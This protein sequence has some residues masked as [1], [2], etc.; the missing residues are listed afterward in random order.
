MSF[1]QSSNNRPS[2]FGMGS[3]SS[4]KPTPPSAPISF[5][6]EDEHEQSTPCQDE[7]YLTLGKFSFSSFA[8]RFTSP[9]PTEVKGNQKDDSME[10]SSHDDHDQRSKGPS[11]EINE[12]EMQEANDDEVQPPPL[13]YESRSEVSEEHEVS[14]DEANPCFESQKEK[15]R[16]IEKM[17]PEPKGEDVFCV[18]V[19]EPKRVKFVTPK[20]LKVP[21]KLS[22]P[23]TKHSPKPQISS[24]EPRHV[25]SPEL[26]E[27]PTFVKA[28]NH[29]EFVQ[30]EEQHA[31]LTPISEESDEL[32]QSQRGPERIPQNSSDQRLFHFSPSDSNRRA[33]SRFMRENPQLPLADDSCEVL[34]E[35]II[36]VEKLLEIGTT[37]SREVEEKIDDSFVE[38][39]DQRYR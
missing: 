25:T 34:V 16:V 15:S 12:E 30:K 8:S 3:S 13:S 21:L 7:S 5:S 18:P 14:E 29:L 24:P 2:F 20:L 22:S 26:S 10:I 6:K 1:F 19:G 27:Q 38:L 23:N 4:S 35:K 31:H 28:N 33:K 36:N 32:V 17:N 11:E 39:L 9:E 37:L